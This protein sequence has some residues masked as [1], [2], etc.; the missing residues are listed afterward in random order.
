MPEVSSFWESKEHELDF[1]VSPEQYI[2][3]K[4]G[5][6]SPL[7]FAWFNRTFPHAKLQV[8]GGS[9]FETDRVQGLTL[10]DFLLDEATGD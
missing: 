8:V 1:V 4:L 5:K 3:V 7:E 2:E 6:T 10:E 9:R